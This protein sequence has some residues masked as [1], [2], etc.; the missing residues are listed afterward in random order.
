[1]ATAT[2]VASPTCEA[3]G[4]MRVKSLKEFHPSAD[5]GPNEYGV[6]HAALLVGGAATALRAARR[7]LSALPAPADSAS[8]RRRRSRLQVP[9]PSRL[10]CSPGGHRS[11]SSPSSVPAAARLAEARSRARAAAAASASPSA[12]LGGETAALTLSPPQGPDIACT[13]REPRLRWCK[14]RR[15][16]ALS[17]GRGASTGRAR[18]GRKSACRRGRLENVITDDWQELA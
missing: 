17:L 12:P 18:P 5:G 7:R 6:R 4:V 2:S 9:L 16:D 3:G 1:M 14:F 11:P 15:M 8:K 10:R 13:I